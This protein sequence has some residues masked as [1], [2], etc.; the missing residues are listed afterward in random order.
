[1]IVYLFAFLT[2]YANLLVLASPIVMTEDGRDVGFFVCLFMTDFSGNIH[3]NL[4]S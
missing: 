1:M 3:V 2:A 4:S